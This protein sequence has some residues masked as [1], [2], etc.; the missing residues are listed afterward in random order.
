MKKSEREKRREAA[1]NTKE[2]RK[3]EREHARK[4][5]RKANRAIKK[6]LGRLKGPNITKLRDLLSGDL[7]LSGLGDEYHSSIIPV[8][9]RSP[10]QEQQRFKDL[11][12]EVL[13]KAPRIAE[14]SFWPAYHILAGMSWLRPISDWTPKGKSKATLFCSL[15]DHLV[16]EYRVPDFLYSV[17][18]VDPMKNRNARALA[19]FFRYVAQGGSP[20]AY[21]RSAFLPVVMTRKMCHEFMHS[22]K[23]MDF[24]Q[25]VRR[26]QA[27]VLGGNRSLIKAICKSSLAR[28]LTRDERFWL[29]VIKWFCENGDLDMD[30][31]GPLIDFISARRRADTRY[32]MKGRTAG[33]L[34]RA[35]EVWHREL[36]RPRAVEKVV[37]KRSGIPEGS[38]KFPGKTPGGQP[39]TVVWDI[40]EIL[41]SEE[42]A[43]EGRRMHHCV[44]A[45][46]HSIKECFI[47]V[48]SLRRDGGRLLT[49]E[50][51]NRGREIVQ[52]RG[53]YNR[54]ATSAELN[55]L[56]RWA[57]ETGLK[58][59]VR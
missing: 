49:V 13:L 33:S 10:K 46:V 45:Y 59:R 23:D 52:A 7:N 53:K 58:L 21:M 55:K 27:I 31:I 40:K 4:V 41:T 9:A 50:V 32:S 20:Y 1:E 42:L 37:F 17:F 25:A 38:W 35:M 26:A 47:S 54:R 14:E 19:H 11:M 39:V 48:W 15:V 56:K 29:S 12:N 5:K 2:S 16:V 22:P 34:V 43:D 8:I 28:G 24:F 18:A 6:A 57:T 30:Q 51:R 3:T 36:A 44:Y